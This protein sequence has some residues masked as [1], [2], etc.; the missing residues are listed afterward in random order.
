MVRLVRF[1]DA[2]LTESQADSFFHL[3]Y[4]IDNILCETYIILDED[5]IKFI[6]SFLLSTY[7]EIANEKSEF[8]MEVFDK[9]ETKIFNELFGEIYTTTNPSFYD[10]LQDILIQVIPAKYRDNILGLNINTWKLIKLADEL[11]TFE[12]EEIDNEY[13]ILNPSNLAEAFESIIYLS[14]ENLDEW[15]YY[16]GEPLRFTAP[17][18]AYKLELVNK[19]FKN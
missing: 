8:K 10:Y 12:G 4:G 6:E 2:G 18:L 17:N 7:P 11:V 13:N 5:E 16:N 19:V 3:V 1:F 9:E 14:K 15:K